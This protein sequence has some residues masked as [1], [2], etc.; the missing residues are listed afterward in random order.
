M[1][2]ADAN[3]H[4]IRRAFCSSFILTLLRTKLHFGVLH[5]LHVFFRPAQRFNALTSAKRFLAIRPMSAIVS[6]VTGGLSHL[7]L[8][9]FYRRS[10]LPSL[11]YRIACNSVAAHETPAANNYGCGGSVKRSR[12]L[13]LLSLTRSF[14]VLR[15]STAIGK[16]DR[17]SVYPKLARRDECWASV[18]AAN[19]AVGTR[20]SFKWAGA[21]EST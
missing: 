17:C 15:R 20:A 2:N 16:P 4:E 7:R 21:H 19:R 14:A 9:A 5:V 1:L 3:K 8:R 10:S 12:L 11:C 6:Y 13:D 18:T